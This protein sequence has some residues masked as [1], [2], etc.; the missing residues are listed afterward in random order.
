MTLAAMHMPAPFAVS[1]GSVLGGLP[2]L[3]FSTRADGDAA[4]HHTPVLVAE[5]VEWLSVS[6][7]KVYLDGTV[8]EGGHA[9][10][11][12]DA[13][14]PNGVV[15][16]IDRDP[17]SVDAARRRLTGYGDRAR[18][19]HGNYADMGDLARQ[20]G[21]EHVDGVLLDLGFSSRQV[22]AEG[23]GFSF[24][25]D[26]PLDMRYDPVGSTAA[27]L[28]NHTDER[29]LADVIYRYG[30]E[31]RSRAVARAIVEARPITTTGL[32]ASVVSR[33]LGGRRGGRH[34]ATRTF[35][36]LRI[37]VN[38]ELMH[39]EV[40]LD[41]VPGLLKPGGRLVVISYHSLED[42]LVK[43]W[44]DREAARCICPPELPVCACEHEASVR[45]VRRR[46]VRPS[47]AET[48][49]NSRSRSARL[50]AVER[51]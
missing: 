36:A 29:D 22:D 51:I 34:P 44:M 3:A 40:G 32:L 11:L 30:E 1:A 14:G 12:L 6:P 35:Q 13:S 21:I 25:R 45:F 5:T 31:R 2:T 37:A 28:L 8:G 47:A 48:D 39:L 33:A 4:V 10:A 46:V 16:G 41:A 38:Q 15:L 17:R 7:G 26:E 24:Q 43:G 20:S 9:E 42:R 50:R 23:Y 49:D 19:V 18:I 27:D